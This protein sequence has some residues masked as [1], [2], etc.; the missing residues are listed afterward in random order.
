ML[1]AAKIEQS[2]FNCMACGGC[3]YG[4]GMY[5]PLSR[6]DLKRLPEDVKTFKAEGHLWMEM[7]E[8]KCPFLEVSMQSFTC[9]IYEN[10]PDA[11]RKFEIGGMPCLF[12]AK[13]GSGV[14]KT[15]GVIISPGRLVKKTHPEK[16]TEEN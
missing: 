13:P 16:S 9:S 6:D 14:R 3:C 2:G 7:N 8:G 10:R 12:K 1:P 11:C 4:N 5:L 15:P